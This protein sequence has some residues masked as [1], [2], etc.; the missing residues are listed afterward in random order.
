MEHDE[1]CFIAPG[2]MSL[3]TLSVTLHTLCGSNWMALHI[4]GTLP[5]EVGQ[6]HAM[7]CAMK[8]AMK[9]AMRRAMKRAMKCAMKCAMDEA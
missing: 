7:M 8:C 2:N 6:K 3:Y 4:R 5:T 9:C 1:P